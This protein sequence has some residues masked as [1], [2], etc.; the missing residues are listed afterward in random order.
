ME[1]L[2]TL[3]SGPVGLAQARKNWA[4]GPSFGRAEA[5][6]SSSPPK[7]GLERRWRGPGI[8]VVLRE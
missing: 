3:F 2:G 4:E 8:R 5:K 1:A 6:S 7:Q